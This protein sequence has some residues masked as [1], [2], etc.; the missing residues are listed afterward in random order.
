[1]PVFAR[2]HRTIRHAALALASLAVFSISGGHWA[3][4]QTIA[5]GQMLWDY[6]ELTGSLVDGARMTFS[7][8][9]PCTMCHAVDEGKSRE[10][11]IPTVLK[12]EQKFEILLSACAVSPVCP[13]AAERG[14]P[15]DIFHGEGRSEE[16]PVPIPIA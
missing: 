7:G 2:L 15:A 9:F 1:M 16:P 11:R 14:Y 12:N 13:P 4:L 6:T 5:W 3:V 10:S 8:Q